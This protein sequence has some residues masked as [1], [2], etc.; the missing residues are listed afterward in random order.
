MELD[1][2]KSK[3]KKYFGTD[4][5]R[6]TAN[7]KLTPE[8][9]LNL[10]K[11]T[12]AYL[13]QY[14]SAPE[15]CLGED[16]RISSPLL[17]DAFSVGFNSM[18]GNVTRLGIVPTGAVSIITRNF[19]YHTGVM[20]SASHN[21]A[22]DN[23][24]K[25]ISE[26]G[27]KY[28]DSAEQSI[29][30]LLNNP[31]N[32]LRSSTK[33]G[34]TQYQNLTNH[35]VQFI[36]ETAKESLQGLNI[37]LDTANGSNYRI[38]AEV[39][40]ILG[41]NVNTFHSEPNGLNINDNCGATHPTVIQQLTVEGHCDYGIVFDGDAD[42]VLICNKDGTLLNG[43]AIMAI[44]A[45][46]L[47]SINKLEK[48][49]VV[50]TIMSNG[51]IIDYLNNQDI[52]FISSDVGDKKVFQLME[53]ENL[54]LG[55][56]QSGHIIFRDSLPTGDGLLTAIYFL[57]AIK[58]NPNVLNH[59]LSNFIPRPQYLLN[60]GMD[61]PSSFLEN[62]ATKKLIQDIMESFGTSGRIHIRPSGTQ[63]I[64]R[65]MIEHQNDILLLNTLESINKYTQENFLLN[66][67]S[68]VNLNETLGG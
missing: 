48:S 26:N 45:N 64:L 47:K 65:I 42:R 33:I 9:A 58:H 31:D 18:G 66:S 41:C 52:H 37:A 16:T 29:E 15:V 35:Y 62:S 28:N 19:N 63:S 10:G 36:L 38:A 56:E 50:G 67:Y 34:S 32:L 20:V 60:L 46:Y 21:P 43:D 61:N 53:S 44:C 25:L 17:A 13:K 39:F 3:H 8:L 54:S 4:G 27:S 7:I 24:I 49:T 59:Y 1:T 11:A 6:G 51:G 57:N 14:H 23:G 30:I 68:I 22:E 5:I 40:T 2:T 12:F 55:G